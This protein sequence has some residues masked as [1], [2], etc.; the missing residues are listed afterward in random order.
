MAKDS[1]VPV[2]MPPSLQ[3]KENSCAYDA[4]MTILYNTWQ[5][6]SAVMTKYF[7]TTSLDASFSLSDSFWQV[8]SG[9]ANFNDIHDT[10]Q[11]ELAAWWPAELQWGRMIAIDI[12]LEKLFKPSLPVLSRKLKC[13][14]GHSVSTS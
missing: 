3:W 12:L 11:K 10:L 14:K 7:V 13:V 9:L 6:D 1:V 4:T 2:N 8:L 5:E